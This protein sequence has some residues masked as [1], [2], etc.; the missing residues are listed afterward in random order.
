MNVELIREVLSIFRDPA[1]KWSF[2]S[3]LEALSYI[4]KDLQA[5]P[6][7]DPQETEKAVGLILAMNLS[8]K[9][10]GHFYLPKRGLLANSYL[11][12]LVNFL[13]RLTSSTAQFGIAP[14]LSNSLATLTSETVYLKLA[15]EVLLSL[16]AR[17][18]VPTKVQRVA[19]SHVIQL[20]NDTEISVGQ[21]CP[22]LE[23][24][25]QARSAIYPHFG[26]L[27]GTSEM[28]S[29]AMQNVDERVLQHFCSDDST[30]PERGSF[31]EFLFDMTFEE[32]AFLRTQMEQF[33]TPVVSREWVETTLNRSVEPFNQFDPM[34]LYRSYY[35]RHFAAD[36]R[37]TRDASG[38]QHT[39][40]AYLMIYLLK[41]AQ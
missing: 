15:E 39:A 12:A 37:R 35:R 26:S 24:A 22:L 28:L 3:E 40:E 2:R 17:E 25:W 18:D 14:E 41:E 13:S 10:S 11:T 5:T 9:D 36:S 32:L 20:W 6:R 34:T 4:Q 30:A 7:L 31:E 29:L 38:P 27:L 21:F 16:T 1:V 8:P 23:S 19:A 33:Q